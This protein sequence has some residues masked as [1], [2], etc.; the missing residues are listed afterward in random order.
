[1]QTLGLEITVA[2]E[3]SVYEHSSDGAQTPP[4]RPVSI[5][6]LVANG[7]SASKW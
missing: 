2:G 1:M 6:N 7:M 3:S 5:R 4:V